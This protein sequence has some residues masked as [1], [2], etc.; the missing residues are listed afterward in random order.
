MYKGSLD[1][2]ISRMPKK[3]YCSNN[4]KK[5]LEVV[6]RDIALR[7]KF[8][9]INSP[10]HNCQ[11]LIFDV[12]DKYAVDKW[13]DSNVSMP[14]IITKNKRN[15]HAHYIYLLKN[16]VAIH[17]H[18]HFK[19][20]RYMAAIERGYIRR[21]GADRGYSGLITRNP[22][23]HPII[24]NG[25]L[26]SL[27]ELDACLDFEDKRRWEDAE[28]LESGIGRNVTMFDSVRFWAYRH[29][30]EFQ[31]VTMFGKAVVSQCELI[32]SGFR[33]PLP[34]SEIK[35]TAKSITKWVWSRRFDFTG[36]RVNR[37]AYGCTRKEAGL[38]T[39]EIRRNVTKA[40]IEDAI[41]KMAAAGSGL[42]HAAIALECGISTKTVQRHMKQISLCICTFIGSYLLIWVMKM[43]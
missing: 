27:S 7:K 34:F 12:D 28:R 8:V 3:P 42:T 16:P 23:K 6:G 5:G 9:Q 26:Y 35:S 25:K 43:M 36:R 39:A 20:V 40:K 37:G 4:L 31:S 41:R 10:A 24:D 13:Q 21:L 14:T 38:V 29:V 11:A 33:H 2:L 1:T 30:L 22:L 32:N 18:A 19:P 17:N 15:G